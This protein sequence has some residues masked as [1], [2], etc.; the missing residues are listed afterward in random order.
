MKPNDIWFL[1]LADQS[2]YNFGLTSFFSFSKY[3]KGLFKYCMPAILSITQTVLD[4]SFCQLVWANR[5]IGYC[6][7]CPPPPVIESDNLVIGTIGSGK[8][9]FYFLY[10]KC[11][12][13]LILQGLGF[14]ELN[15]N[16][17]LLSVMRQ[18]RLVLGSHNIS[19][20]MKF[21]W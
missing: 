18:D 8:E 16:L 4:P 3:R 1:L 17:N 7:V 11:F 15:I 10:T 20:M 5:V 9:K 21:P 12:T 2:Y 6:A 13:T 14:L 19:V